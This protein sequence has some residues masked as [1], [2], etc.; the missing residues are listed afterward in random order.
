MEST[1]QTRK[2]ALRA[3]QDNLPGLSEINHDAGCMGD[4]LRASPGGEIYRPALT[5]SREYG[6]FSVKNVLAAHSFHA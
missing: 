5:S 6:E 2:G 3:G 4:R 1:L